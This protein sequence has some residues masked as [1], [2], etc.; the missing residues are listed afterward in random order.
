MDAFFCALGLNR[1]CDE[2]VVKRGGVGDLEGR[3]GSDT[4]KWWKKEK[5]GIGMRRQISSS[6]A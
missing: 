4:V 2:W 6:F 3:Y 1:R 5:N